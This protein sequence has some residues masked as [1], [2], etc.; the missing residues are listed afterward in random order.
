MTSTLL[1]RWQTR[2]LLIITVGLGVTL[3]FMF[4][5]V[6]G[7]T[8]EIFLRVLGYILGLGFGWDILYHYGEK[9]R[10]DRDWPGFFQ[11]L[12]A[13]W[14]AVFLVFLIKKFE[15]PGVPGDN[16]S[17]KIFFLHYSLVWVAIYVSSQSLMRVLF[18]YWR[19]RGGQWF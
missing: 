11:G 18:P 7:I 3:P 17:V 4:L 2:F 15:V 6:G 5:Q 12:A 14:E 9:L 13:I 16:F 1:G 19:F 10:W 8:G